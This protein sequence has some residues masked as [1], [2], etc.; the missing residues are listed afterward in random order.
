MNSEKQQ[1]EE[2]KDC[3][4][5]I[6]DDIEPEEQDQNEGQEQ[7]AQQKPKTKWE[8]K[9]RE[10]LE[11][12]YEMMNAQAQNLKLKNSN[13]ASAHGMYVEE[14]VST[15]ADIAK[16]CYHTMKI[17]LFREVVKVSDREV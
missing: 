5:T 15:A 13:F 7:S 11:K 12:F 17:P 9:V 6:E 14:N 4:K 16:L 10:C 8:L 2:E 1:K 3:H